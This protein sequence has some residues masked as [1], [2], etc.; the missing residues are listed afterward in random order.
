MGEDSTHA[1]I[2]PDEQVN[3]GCPKFCLQAVNKQLVLLQ[4][5]T[6]LDFLTPA[7]LRRSSYLVTLSLSLL[8]RFFLVEFCSLA[9]H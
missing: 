9:L 5:C 7:K 8:L 1:L 4:S 2:G 6:T 3:L